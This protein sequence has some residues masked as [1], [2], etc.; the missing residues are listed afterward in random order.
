MR[1]EA[2]QR[3]GSRRCPVVEHGPIEPHGGSAAI[4]AVDRRRAR[5]EGREAQNVRTGRLSPPPAAASSA[6]RLGSRR[7][8]QR[9]DNLAWTTPCSSSRRCV[10]LA[11]AL[12]AHGSG[13]CGAGRRAARAA[14]QVAQLLEPEVVVSIA[15]PVADPAA[16]PIDRGRRGRAGPRGRG[17][18]ADPG[19][20]PRPAPR[21]ADRLE[22]APR[23]HRRGLGGAR[24]P[25]AG[26]RAARAPIRHAAHRGDHPAVACASPDPVTWWR[27]S[28]R[29]ASCS[30]AVTSPTVPAAE[31][32]AE[33][34]AMGVAH[35]SAVADGIAEVTASIGVA[36]AVEPDERPESV[37]RRAIK[38]GQP[39]ACAGR[40]AHRDLRRRADLG[41]H[42]RGVRR[43]AHQRRVRR[44]LP[45]DRELHDRSDRGV[46]V[47]GALG[48]PRA[49]S[50]APGPSSCRRRE[51]NGAIVAVGSRAI[52]LACAQ[53]ARWHERSA[54]TLK[55][56]VNLLDARARGSYAA[57][58]RGAGDRRGRASRPGSV[59]LEVTEETLLA[60]RDAVG[61]G[62]APAARRRR[63]PRDR[64]LR[65]RR[66]VARVAQAVPARR[67]QDRRRLRGGARPAAATATRCA[68]P[69]SS[70]PTRSGSARSPRASRRSSSGQA[71]R[72][73][74]CELA[75]GRLFGPARPA[76]DYGDHPASTLGLA[77]DSA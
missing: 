69:S 35:P 22:R 38:A 56:N 30:C 5:P 74:G 49:R 64:R 12:V 72:S 10:A 52:E 18:A 45:A 58:A 11:I 65:R 23:P 16:V 15:S 29:S 76:A 44:A 1:V 53:M 24:Q 39:C 48:P 9:S 73:L 2:H 31:A 27:T 46:R 60:D 34:V 20:R 71:L 14:D 36:L 3:P 43:R 47:A 13:P 6:S 59:W 50:A 21:L 51:R 54:T 7:D 4:R 66:L 62:A 63:A 61:R 32:L 33:R 17:S 25:A 68:V 75:Q 19:A 28:T 40:G 42:R 57:G 77:P 67:D 70:S 41:H 55:L 26:E 37:L 8:V